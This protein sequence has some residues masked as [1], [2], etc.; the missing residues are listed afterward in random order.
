MDTGARPFVAADFP[1]YAEAVARENTI[2]AAA[3][4][5]VNEKIC[6]LEVRPLTAWLY[7]WLALVRSPFLIPGMTAGALVEKPE[8]VN[9]V[10][11]FLWIVSPMFVP[12]A[13]QRER[14]W[15]RRTARDR[16]NMAFAP[17]LQQRVDDVCREILEYV[18]EA[19]VDAG[20]PD[21]GG[22]KNYFAFEVEIADELHRHYGY[23]VDFWRAP[24]DG[25]NPVHVPLKLIFQFRKRRRQAAGDVLWNG[26]DEYLSKGLAAMNA[27]DRRLREYEMEMARQ[28]APEMG[29]ARG[30]EPCEYN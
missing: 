29:E 17:I 7:R 27:R 23:R 6:G 24:A 8:I 3:C 22:D 21:P 5:G 4:L 26:S 12:G 13:R 18:D 15:Q 28:P 2:R 16:F 9:D 25:M 11:A 1:G 14:W 10:M 30:G 20:A 19:F